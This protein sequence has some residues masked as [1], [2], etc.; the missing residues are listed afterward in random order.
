MSQ[1]NDLPVPNTGSNAPAIEH[2]TSWAWWIEPAK[3]RTE[4]YR[5]ILVGG[6]TDENGAD[7]VA[8]VV[9]HHGRDIEILLSRE[10]A[11]KLAETWYD[12]RSAG[13]GEKVGP[14]PA[15]WSFERGATE[16]IRIFVSDD[17]RN[18]GRRELVELHLGT[19]YRAVVPHLS[20]EQANE[21]GNALSS[22]RIAFRTDVQSWTPRPTA[23]SWWAEPEEIK[24]GGQTILVGGA[25]YQDGPDIAALVVL[26][27]G[28]SAD[29]TLSLGSL[30]QLEAALGRV[31]EALAAP[32][33]GAQ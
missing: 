27:N 31:R 1:P 21:F 30:G 9:T 15:T 28:W 5:T 32:V 16:D 23:W 18:G 20:P 19:K 17:R 2:P 12:A 3:I 7:I 24:A 13:T 11:E 22:I 29:V 14:V 25:S 8:M 33:D 26:A 4:D 6:A 10:Q